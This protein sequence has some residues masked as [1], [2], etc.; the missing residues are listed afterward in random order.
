[1]NS[2]TFDKA[3]AMEAAAVNQHLQEISFKLNLLPKF[4]SDVLEMQQEFSWVRVQLSQAL[5][6]N[7]K[8]TREMSCAMTERLSAKNPRADL[9]EAELRRANLI[10]Y[11]FIPSQR[12]GKTLK[13]EVM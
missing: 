8:M 10:L 3:N 12:P 4:S 2:G 11:D 7:E 13:E 9:L 1:M 6:N 5:E